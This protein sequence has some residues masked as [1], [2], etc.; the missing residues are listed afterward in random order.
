[1]F[2][3]NFPNITE[4]SLAYLADSPICFTLNLLFHYDE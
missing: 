1:M 2:K 4:Q 3:H